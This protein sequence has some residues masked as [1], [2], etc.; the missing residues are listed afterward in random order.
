VKHPDQPPNNFIVPVLEFQVDMAALATGNVASI[1][2]AASEDLPVLP[3]PGSLTP[4]PMDDTPA[5]S[6][7]DQLKATDTATRKR[8][9]NSGPEL[10]STGLKPRPTVESPIE[11]LDPD[12]ATTKQMNMLRAVLAKQ[13]QITD[14]QEVHDVVGAYIGREVAS[15]KDLSRA[16]ASKAIDMAQAVE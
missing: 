15:L 2:T 4:V 1:G 8:R 12:A 11:E 14:N 13:R 5:P 16:E 6:L 10:P 9:A 3:G 7:E